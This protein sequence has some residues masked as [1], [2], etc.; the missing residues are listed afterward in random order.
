[1]VSSY[2]GIIC[3]HI[4]KS[5]SAELFIFDFFQPWHGNSLASAHLCS[6]GTWMPKNLIQM[7][8]LC[9]KEPAR[10]GQRSGSMYRVPMCELFVKLTKKHNFHV[11]GYR[12]P[13]LQG[14]P[15]ERHMF[16]FR[17]SN[18]DNKGGGWDLGV[19]MWIHIYRKYIYSWASTIG[20]WEKPCVLHGTSGVA[21]RHHSLS[22]KFIPINDCSS[23][24]L[25]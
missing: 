15:R 23:S 17:W 10:Q 12:G 16:I 19:R 8:E 2:L 1:M 25:I 6:Y 22:D 11:R 9:W 4:Y 13:P 7:C 5:I 20:F 24:F 18:Q 3:T 21:L 14:W